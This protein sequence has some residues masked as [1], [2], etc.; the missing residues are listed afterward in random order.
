MNGVLVC[1]SPSRWRAPVMICP[2]TKPSS[3]NRSGRGFVKWPSPIPASRFHLDFHSFIADFQGSAG[4]TAR[5]TCHRYFTRADTIFITSNNCLWGL[6][7]AAL[8]AGKTVLV[9]TYVIR[10]GFVVLDPTVVQS[11]AQRRL[12]SYL[13]GMEGRII[14]CYAH[15]PGRN[16]AP[17]HQNRSH[18]YGYQRDQPLGY[19][20]G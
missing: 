16:A 4:A 13:D 7:Y 12:A 10:R 5:L 18:G 11:E 20:L 3:V 1:H 2:T 15:Q 17:E 19:P 6:R 14:W 9:T 8:A